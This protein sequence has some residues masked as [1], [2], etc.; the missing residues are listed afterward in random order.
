MLLNI[1]TIRLPLP[2]YLG[3]VNC[4]LIETTAGY[5]L[6]DTGCSFRRRMLERG[7]E[8]A[9]CMP[10]DLK[11]ILLTHGDFDHTGSA[12]Y[13]RQKYGAKIAMHSGD[14]G[15][16]E[17]GNMFSNRK[18]DSAL[19]NKVASQIYGFGLSER[20]STDIFLDERTDL[21]EYG[22]PGSILSIPGHSS[23]SIGILTAGSDT[24]N[25]AEPAAANRVHRALFCGDLLV[26][27]GR[28]P[29]LNSI[30]DD[31]AA[32]VAS[33]EK[34]RSMEIRTVFPGHGKPFVLERFFLSLT[35]DSGET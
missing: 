20:F 25:A 29:A 17:S 34:L 18:A 30:I 3:A 31:H 1:H 10:G 13:L 5:F 11:L 16:A 24:D 22:F 32:A 9:G 26:N 6:V 19:I 21:I 28:R 23:G 8:N 7:L 27:S 4:Y 12:G 33:L 2:M 35:L 15:M 14:A